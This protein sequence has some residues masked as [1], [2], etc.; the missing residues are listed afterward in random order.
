[1]SVAGTRKQ[2]VIVL[3]SAFAIITISVIATLH[4][5]LNNGSV[6]PA[7]ESGYQNVTFTDAVLH[8]EKETRR[9]YSKNIKQLVIDNH[10]SHYDDN[11][12]IYKIFFKADMKSED[13][14]NKSTNLFYVNCFVKSRNGQISKY[15]VFEEVDEV[16]KPVTKNETNAFG[17][18]K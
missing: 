1:M 11:L 13:S 9:T 7:G 8:C 14:K 15:E 6:W 18:P 16:T 5:T 10:S 3:S 4:I 17:W 2:R 12:F